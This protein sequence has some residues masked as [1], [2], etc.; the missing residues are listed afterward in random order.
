MFEREHPGW[1]VFWLRIPPPLVDARLV[2]HVKRCDRCRKLFEPLSM[3]RR[4]R[5]TCERCCE[6][7][8]RDG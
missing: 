5:R 8:V 7:A 6:K 2:R 4:D 1:A 3:D